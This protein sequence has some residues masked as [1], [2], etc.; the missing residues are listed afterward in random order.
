MVQSMMMKVSELEN[1]ATFIYK[2]VNGEGIG[3]SVEVNHTQGKPK[4][5]ISKKGEYENIISQRRRD[6]RSGNTR[7]M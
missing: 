5:G 4:V 6:W 2:D 1:K 7:V 3:E